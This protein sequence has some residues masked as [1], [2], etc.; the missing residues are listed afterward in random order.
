MFLFIENFIQ[1]TVAKLDAKIS[2]LN[3][4]TETIQLSALQ[5]KVDSIYL[6]AVCLCIHVKN[7]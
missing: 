5:Q 6:I 3:R 7:L 2:D 4:R 1:S